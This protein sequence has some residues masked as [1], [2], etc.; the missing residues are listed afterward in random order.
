MQHSS[1]LS[2]SIEFLNRMFYV[3]GSGPSGVACAYGLLR[4]GCDVTML[5]AGLTLE[6]DRAEKLRRLKDAGPSSWTGHQAAFLRDGMKA[7][8]NGVP[9]KLAYGSSFPY[10]A[11]VGATQV[12]Q[13]AANLRSSFALGGF[14]NVWGSAVMPYHAEDIRD[15]PISVER[16]APHYTA[17]FDF[18]PLAAKEDQLTRRFPL[19]ARCFESLQ[20]SRQAK[21]LLRDL[22]RHRDALNQIGMEFGNARLA[23]WARKEGYACAYCALC[24]YGCPY[25]LIYSSGMTVPELARFPKFRY[26]PGVNV[27]RVEET[28]TGVR[29]VGVPSVPGGESAEQA[30]VGERVYLACG[31]LQ[32]TVLLLRSLQVYETP[33]SALDSQYF[34]L[35]MLRFR[36]TSGI[37]N[38]ALYTLA[39]VFLEI[40]DPI[41]S[42]YTIHL[43]AYTYNDLFELPL[44]SVLGPLAKVFSAELLVS[45]LMLFQGLL[46]SAHSTKMQI[47]L[48][49][50]PS[51]KEILEVTG[52]PAAETA[53]TLRAV[54]K[55]LF[56]ARRMLGAIPLSPLARIA[57]P[58]RGDHTGGTFPMRRDPGPLETDV[59][60]RLQGWKRVHLVDASVFPS[61]PATTITLT[62]MAN[63]HRIASELVLY[64]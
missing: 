31:V 25:E 35:P 20:T 17:V 3:I 11:A 50:S 56:A 24:L 45:R 33:I 51:G 7:G 23:V 22:E 15:W 59:F 46:H 63:A 48:K 2:A 58:G 38:E 36:G 32:T 16:L 5:D 52:K 29:I 47:Q 64:V 30:F 37:R 1:F 62:A 55:K 42:P 9:V 57:P 60:G 61:V 44:R 27:H 4:Q 28:G 54:I 43:Q 53:R 49:R 10:R 34:L 26:V 8:L 40:N 12:R 14:S 21:A 39:Q 19:Y 13:T 6:P 18:M 41:L